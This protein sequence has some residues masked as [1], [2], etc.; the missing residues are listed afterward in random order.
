MILFV[1]LEPWLLNSGKISNLKILFSVL[2]QL[3]AQ[4]HYNKIMLTQEFYISK[5]ENL[6][7]KS[8]TGSSS[9]PID[10]IKLEILQGLQ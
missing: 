9:T 3:S 1:L 4:I 10:V 5:R 8:Y 6:N 2:L 7:F